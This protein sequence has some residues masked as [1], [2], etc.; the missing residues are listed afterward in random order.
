M[1]ASSYLLAATLFFGLVLSACGG[2]S[3]IPESTPTAGVEMAETLPPPSATSPVPS[4]TPQPTGIPTATALP[5]ETPTP[6]FTP[7]PTASFTPSPSPTPQ[8]NQPGIYPLG[9]CQSHKL[10]DTRDD[11]VD[12]CIRYVSIEPDGRM[13]FHLSWTAHLAGKNFI[14]PRFGRYKDDLVDNLGNRYNWIERDYTRNHL[15]DG[16][17][18]E[19]WISFEKAKQGATS[20]TFLIEAYDDLEF[21]GL[22]F[23]KPFIA[24]LTQALGLHPLTLAYRDELWEVATDEVSGIVLNHLKIEGCKIEELENTGVQGRLKNR[25]ELGEITYEIYGQSGGEVSVRE[26]LPVAGLEGAVPLLRVS[27][28][29]AESLQ[30]IFDISEVLATLNSMSE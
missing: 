8:L 17:T 6:T 1:K 5:S 3:Q 13:V 20:F 27:I 2:Q 30:C 15:W 28:P 7:E 16:D 29:N 9:S 18:V 11:S 19:G 23:A 12:F 24:T 4:D 21:R 22:S 14:Y 10:V 26:Y 25:I